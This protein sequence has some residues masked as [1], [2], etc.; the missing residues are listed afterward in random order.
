MLDLLAHW[1]FAPGAKVNVGVLN[2]T[3]KKYTDWADVNGILASSL[4][5]DRYTR[6]GRSLSAS[7]SLSW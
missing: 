4:V 2:L 7:L 1:H 6:P 5:L 3:D